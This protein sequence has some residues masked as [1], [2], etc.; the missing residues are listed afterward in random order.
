MK[1][2]SRD[3]IK[4]AQLL[5]EK[6]FYDSSVSR[7]YYAAYLAAWHHL[8]KIG[9]QPLHE[10]KK[11]GIYWRHDLFPELLC[12]EYK[13]IGPDQMSKFEILYSRRI[14]ADYYVDK[15]VKE[16]AGDSFKL[17]SDFISLFLDNKGIIE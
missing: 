6:E 13:L 3:N 11:G 9:I 16:E 4:A 5:E 1:D 7:S 10:A 8:S 17:A 15:V 12:D 2:K 14:K